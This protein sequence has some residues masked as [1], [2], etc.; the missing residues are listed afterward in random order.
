MEHLMF[1]I[2]NPLQTHVKIR[3][4]LYIQ[5]QPHNEPQA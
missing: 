1:N 4:V 3:V 5:I 2:P